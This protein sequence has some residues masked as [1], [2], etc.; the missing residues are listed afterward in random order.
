MPAVKANGGGGGNFAA[1]EGSSVAPFTVMQPAVENNMITDDLNDKVKK[2]GVT[3]TALLAK[4][5]AMALVQHPVLN[6]TSIIGG[7]IT[8]I[9]QMQTRYFHP[10][11]SGMFGVDRF[12]AILPLGQG[13][14]TVV[15]ASKPTVVADVDGFISVKIKTLVCGTSLDICT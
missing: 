3:M 12:D 10:V 7:L 8:P 1:I 14:I 4:A 2:K 15:G 5:T 11:Q 9:L 13:A 6:S